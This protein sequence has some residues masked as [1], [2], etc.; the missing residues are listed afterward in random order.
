MLNRT[1]RKIQLS[2]SG[3]S[4]LICLTV[5]MILGTV[6]ID[7]TLAWL[8]SESN[9]VVNTFT[10]G[11]ID[12]TLSET[13]TTLDQDQ[14]EYTNLY[15]MVPGQIIGDFDGGIKKDPLVTIAE[16]SEACWLFVELVESDNFDEFMEYSVL[17]GNGHWTAL[18]SVED[19]YYREVTEAETQI[20]YWIIENNEVR[21]K[22]NIKEKLN[23]LQE[24]PTLSIT[25]YAVQRNGVE[26]VQDAWALI[27]STAGTQH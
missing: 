15:E 17:T 1:R 6:T 10:Y 20:Q 21:V 22:D 13:D 23:T 12:L 27:K 25:A 14:N 24:L 2:K 26:T 5:L 8:V 19:V 16:G 9:P 11:K 3:K 4:I 7:Q 18:D